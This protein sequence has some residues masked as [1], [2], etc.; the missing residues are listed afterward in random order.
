MSVLLRL[1]GQI[2]FLTNLIVQNEFCLKKFKTFFL[3]VHID[4]L[5]EKNDQNKCLESFCP[6]KIFHKKSLVPNFYTI[7]Q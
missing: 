7:G 6:M 3:I 5:L 2:F 1:F 4:M